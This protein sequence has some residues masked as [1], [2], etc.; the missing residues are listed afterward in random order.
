MFGGKYQN[1]TIC[2]TFTILYCGHWVEQFTG[3]YLSCN[4]NLVILLL[5]NISYRRSYLYLIDVDIG[6]ASVAFL[7]KQNKYSVVK[8]VSEMRSFSL[9]QAN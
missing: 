2:F 9:P 7:F 5:V 3:T 4:W 1:V 8:Y 6:T